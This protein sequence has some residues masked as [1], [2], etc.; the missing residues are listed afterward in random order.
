MHV[1]ARTALP[2][3]I[4]RLVDDPMLGDVELETH[5]LE[6][7]EMAGLTLPSR[8]VQRKARWTLAEYRITHAQTNVVLADLT[9][10][11]SV[12]AVATAATSPSRFTVVVDSVA[13]GVWI[14]DSGLYHT[15]A[16]E[17]SDRIVLIEAPES[18]GRT[19]AAIAKAR[20]RWPGKQ[21][22]PV[23]NSHHHFDH[24]GGL[25]AAISQGLPI[26]THAANTEFFEEFVYPRRHTINPDALERTPKAL[27]ITSVR[28]KLVVEDAMRS[29]EL[30]EATGAVHSGSALLVYV[31]AARVLIQGDLEMPELVDNVR[32]L[33]LDVDV[34]LGLHDR[35][36]PWPKNPS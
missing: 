18:D 16:V 31:P 5:F 12:R 2:V 30:Y 34:L 27:S 28:G 15:I 13:P 10:S 9:A 23:V 1:D 4:G 36:A 6:W 19:L 17:Q 11:D 7:R 35:P 20:E 25:R 14:L 29:V 21:L 8:I 22:G 32:R 26:I 33:G 3:R 24:A